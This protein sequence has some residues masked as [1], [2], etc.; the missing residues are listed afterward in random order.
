MLL[1]CCH[2]QLLHVFYKC[3]KKILLS[4]IMFRCQF[5]FS[6]IFCWLINCCCEFVSGT[7]SGNIPM[8]FFWHCVSQIKNVHSTL[9]K[10]PFRVTERKKKKAKLLPHI[11]YNLKWSNK[12][13]RGSIKC[14]WNSREYK[15]NDGTA[16]RNN[17]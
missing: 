5:Q 7:T 10:N 8:V 15:M 13:C 6:I 14:W 3:K 12:V 17:H 11:L 4:F 9:K 2:Y 16:K 1:M